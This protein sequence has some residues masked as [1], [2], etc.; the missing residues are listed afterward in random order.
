M[1]NLTSCQQAVDYYLKNIKINQ[2]LNAI[3]EIFDTQAR[4]RA[5]QL[6]DQRKDGQPLKKLHGVVIAIKDVICYQ[7]FEMKAASKMLHGFK[8]QFTATALQYLLDEDAI[9]IGNCNC[10]EFAMGSSNE[11]SVYG[12]VLNAANTAHVPGGSSGGSAV[13]V[14]AK[15]CMLSLGSDTG[16]SVRQPADHCGI[17]GFKPSYGR[18]SRYGL[19]AYASSFD[20]IGI[21]GNSVEDVE[22]L[23]NIMSAPD[24][25]DSTMMRHPLHKNA[26]QKKV[27]KFCFFPEMI[28]HPNLDQEIAA[29][30]TQTIQGLKDGGHT[31][32]AES[33]SLLDFIV[34]AYYVLTT[35]EA[36]SN[37]SRY[38][39][40]RFGHRSAIATDNIQ[41]FYKQN[42]SEGFGSEVK[43]RIMLG[44]F[45]L[46]TGYYEAYY[47][48]AQKIRRLLC[49]L[50]DD[51][52]QQYDAIIMP[53]APTTAPLL[54][55]KTEDSTAVYLAD[56]FTVFAN[57]T[58]IPAI[59]LPLFSHSNNMPYGVQLM[60]KKDN[61]L[62]LLR[63]ASMVNR[64]HG[65]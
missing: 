12:S 45:V 18:I 27:F 4:L 32:M 50:V 48:K 37:L 59:A 46:S 7:G 8:S 28:N 5:V 61:E 54:N 38:D 20:Q 42:R 30:I 35:A 19:I 31:V 58:G 60:A 52:F 39:G 25:R 13:A 34:P 53:V 26:D 56:V 57:L 16:G 43:K 62:P 6:D 24:A 21:F 9:I 14:Q 55:A 64:L 10:D 22:C 2:S 49:D 29:S 15:L 23:L 11:F 40:V 41:E 33:F 47:G 51:I 1:G 17:I 36:S 63:I 3:V 65:R 44:N